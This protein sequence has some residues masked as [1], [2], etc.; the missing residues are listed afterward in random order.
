MKKIILILPFL[1]LTSCSSQ[2]SSTSLSLDAPNI[3][4]HPEDEN[5]DTYISN[6]LK[7]E[8]NDALNNDSIMNN[9]ANGDAYKLVMYALDK[10]TTYD[11]SLLLSSS[12]VTAHVLGIS[13]D[14]TVEAATFNTPEENFNQ[15]ISSS[16]FV[17]TAFRFYDEKEKITAHE[18]TNPSDWKNSTGTTYTYDEYI[19]TYGKLFKPHYYV[20][21]NY[22][23]DNYSTFESIQDK[24]KR[25]VNSVAIYNINEETVL[26]SSLVQHDDRYTITINLDPHKGTAAYQKQIEKT[27][28]LNS[29]PVF[30]SSLLTFDLDSELNL[31]T[32]TFND[33]YNI[34]IAVLGKSL[35][36]QSMTVNY[37]HS[38]SSKFE[39]NNKIVDV[40]IP[41]KDEEEFNGYSL[42]D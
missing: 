39:Y 40:K 27:G 15:N 31:I 4:S 33:S 2:N 32:A 28:D 7:N 13:Y 21:S 19:N 41:S 24:N 11:Y 5:E 22:L 25:E 14:Q 36:T 34:D 12:T 6:S 38:D 10:Q 23:T 18:C 42:L 17:K 35:A 9:Y 29:L 8:I 30:E 16:L 26:G 37:F 3:T 20:S 1:L